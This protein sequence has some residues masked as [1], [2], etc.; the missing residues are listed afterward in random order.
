MN[1]YKFSKTL[2]TSKKGKKKNPNL[3]SIVIEIQKFDWNN[4]SR[5][6]ASKE[7][8]ETKLQ[9]VC[10]IILESIQIIFVSLII[11]TL[12]VLIYFGLYNELSKLTI[13]ARNVTVSSEGPAA[14]MYPDSMG[15]YKILKDIYRNYRAVYQHV[16]RE[17]RFIIF[18]HCKE[19]GANGDFWYIT[20]DLEADS[21]FIRR[22]SEG[23]VIV[24]ENGWQYI[25]KCKATG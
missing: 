4:P 8:D 18:V 12:T 21:G 20:S 2:L 25:K 10:K 17:D 3:H 16:N 11:L 1:Y 6:K 15:Q 23:E 5:E 24:P 7:I 9:T 13:A 14:E 19:D 22:R